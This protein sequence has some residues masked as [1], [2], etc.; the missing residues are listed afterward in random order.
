M[1]E[2]MIRGGFM[3]II[4]FSDLYKTE[5]R[6][7]EPYGAFQDYW[8]N[9]GN[10][11]SCLNSPKTSHTLL[12]FKNCSGIIK[13]KD[14]TVIYATEGNLLYTP[15][16]TEYSIR[17]EGTAPGQVSSV[18]FHFQLYDVNN[19]EFALSDKPFICLEKADTTTEIDFETIASEMERNVFCVPMIL[20]C[21]YRI[22]GHISAT[23]HNNVSRYNYSYI[24][25]GIQLLESDGNM[26]IK[27]IAKLCGMSEC[28]F[29]RIFQEY[30]GETPAKFR[31]NRRM[32]KAKQMLLSDMF[33]VQ[34]IAEKL[35][36]TD[37]HHFSKTF[38]S[39]V[40]VSPKEY[41]KKSRM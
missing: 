29:R 24:R 2:Y 23:E 28:Y 27:D 13:N 4:N 6:I 35:H 25:K 19:N 3:N 26:K 30:S 21:I 14:G 41:I 15:K 9:V 20:S 40:G 16:G 37:I 39:I 18:F 22:L 36:F 11:F 38:K 12:W 34:E 10:Y 17:F 32:E 1:I 31:Q 8:Y 33:S 5:F 7:G